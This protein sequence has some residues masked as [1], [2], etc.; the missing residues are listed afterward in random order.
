MYADYVFPDLTYLER[1]EFHGSHP[2][3]AQKAQPVRNP[4]IAPIPGT[5]TVFGQ[6]LPMSLES[7]ILGIA[8]K[9]GL[10]GFGPA[11]MGEGKPLVRPEDFYLKMVANI[12]A[13][14]KPL[15]QVPDADDAELKQFA[16]A[17]RHL[18]ATVFNP[19]KWKAAVGESWWPKVVYVLNRGGRYQDY[20][21]AFD[22]EKFTN[23][24]G[25]LVNLYLEKV[26]A[27]KSPMTG[28]KLTGIATYFPV[29]DVLG[30]EIRDEV[31]GYDLHLITY[32][33]VSQTK[34]RTVVDYWLNAIL[35][36]NYILL[37]AK[38][39]QRLGLRDGVLVRVTSKSNPKGVWDLKNGRQKPMVGAVKA[40][41]GLL[42]GV[43]AFSLGRGHWANGSSDLLIDGTLVKGDLRRA[44]G[45][46]AN[47]AMRLDDYLKNTCLV[48][49]VGGSASF[50][51]TKV[52]LVKEA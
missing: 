51:D 31:D 5:V 17:R 29:M 7:M 41:E 13:G 37:N 42:P 6:T 34:S 26:A 32:R 8:E 33:E 21:R 27:A 47:A 35:D 28:K 23:E 19:A 16:G 48:D 30:R 18:P 3:I 44:T 49:P 50:Y 38:D 10:P 39:A 22:G 12:A 46:H 20:A 11:G 9:L 14:D 45:V 4:A 52:R 40:I 36:T 25:Q 43:V 1:W 24:Y 15:D 2:C